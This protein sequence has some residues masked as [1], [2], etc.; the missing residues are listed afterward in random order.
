MLALV[1][2]LYLRTAET[3]ARAMLETCGQLASGLGATQ[4]NSEDKDKKDVKKGDEQSRRDATTGGSIGNAPL[5]LW[6]GQQFLGKEF[7][8]LS[9]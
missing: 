2:A 9:L 1:S 8:L 3:H 6:V 4:K 5:G 7:S